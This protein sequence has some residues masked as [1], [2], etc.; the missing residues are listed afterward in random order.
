M[1]KAS[2]GPSAVD[3]AWLSDHPLP[4][5]GEGMDKNNRGSVLIIGGSRKVPGGLRLTAEAAFCAGAGKVQ[6]ATVESIAL[7][8]GMAVPEAGVIALSETEG[9]EIDAAIEDRL[10]EALAKSDCMVLGPAMTD[11]DGAGALVD[12]VL[13]AEKLPDFLILDAAAIFAARDRE[14]A[15]ANY[16]GDLIITANEDELAALLDRDVDREPKQSVREIAKRF[17]AIAMLKRSDTLIASP[18]GELLRYP[19]GGVG[20]A[21]GGSGDVLAGIL[22]ALLARGQEP[23]A[24]AAWA[25]WLHGEAGRRLSEQL[26]P[27]GLLA[28][29]LPALVPGLMRGAG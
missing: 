4:V 25:V 29:E 28:R 20:L 24:A 3:A 7:S 21:T 12:S 1:A 10:N 22:A 5:H 14:K 15:F 26:G 2:S 18:A 27:I 19:G 6:M 9:G 16:S 11:K 17:S 13:G 23:L 8:L